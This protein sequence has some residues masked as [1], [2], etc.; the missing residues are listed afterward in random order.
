MK[1]CLAQFNPTVGA[2]KENTEKILEIFSQSVNKGAELVVFSELS[3]CG[4]PPMDFLE[5][6]W[7]IKNIEQNIDIIIKKSQQ[8]P[9][10]GLIIGSP[11]KNPNLNGKE[12]FNSALLISNGKILFKQSKTLL[13]SYDVFD[14]TRYFEPAK[15]IETFCFKGLRLGITICEDAWTFPINGRILYNLS[16]P[17]ELKKMGAEIIINLSASPFF[18]GKYKQ[19]FNIFSKHAKELNIPFFFINQIGGNDE[20]IFDGRSMA[21]DKNGCLICE[22]ENCKEDYKIIEHSSSGNHS[23]SK[24]NKEKSIYNALLLGIRDYF[25]KCGFSKALLGLSG[26]IDSAIVL[27]LASDALGPE[28]VLAIT[29]PSPYSSS[30]SIHDSVKLANN[31]GVELKTI[32]ID[33]LFKEFL[34]ALNPLFNGLKPDVTEENLQARIRGTLLMALSNKYSYLLLT[35][36]NKSEMAVGYCTLY[37]DM[38]GGLSVISDLPKTMVYKLAKYINKNKEIIPINI[39]TKPPSAELRPNQCDQDS[40]P[41]Y[42][43][44]DDILEQYIQNN[45]NLQEITA[46]GYPENTVKWVINA[47]IKNEYKRKQAPIGLKLT[48]K[49]FG[50]GRRFPIAAKYSIKIEEKL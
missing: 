36:G 31:L 11:I 35:T 41:E 45:K 44:L 23:I 34:N 5:Q 28:N 4:Y 29:M 25:R 32:R 19:R 50:I 26:G 38:N 48:S 30:G 3:I 27:T 49:A 9:D 33:N 42:D 43:I 47:I 8:Y 10:A 39:I 18:I 12:L 46:M 17:N 21:I 15:S 6:P 14:E 22:L 13:P 24:E 1:I 16:P 20:L 37:G 40:L 2:I 7:F